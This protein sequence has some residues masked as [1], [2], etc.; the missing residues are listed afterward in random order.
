MTL[1]LQW[2]VLFPSLI[3]HVNAAG[4]WYVMS[5]HTLPETQ[6]TVSC[7][8]LCRRQVGGSYD[9]VAGLFFFFLFAQFASL[10]PLLGEPPKSPR[11]SPPCE[12]TVQRCPS[13]YKP[14]VDSPSL[15]LTKQDD[16]LMHEKFWFEL[17]ASCLHLSGFNVELVHILSENFSASDNHVFCNATVFK[18]RTS[19]FPFFLMWCLGPFFHHV[20]HSKHLVNI[21]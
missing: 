12:Q 3:V 2:L 14:T 20:Q 18:D 9:Q 10:W 4:C 1:S 13:F 17:N 6:H 15:I 11:S 21:S 16:D 19:Q 8:C 5:E 7:R